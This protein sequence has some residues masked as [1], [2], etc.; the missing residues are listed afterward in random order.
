MILASASGGV[1]IEE[2]AASNPQAIATEVIEP[3]LGLMPFQIRRLT[4]SLELDTALA[5]RLPRS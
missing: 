2:T 4:A 1:D 5:F 3:V